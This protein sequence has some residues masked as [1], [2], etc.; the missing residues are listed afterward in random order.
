VSAPAPPAPARAEVSHLG[1]PQVLATRRGRALLG[2]GL[3][4]A[5]LLAVVVAGTVLQPAAALTDL[6]ARRQP[7]SLAHPFG[8]DW[9]GRDMLARTLVGLRTSLA[10]GALAA[11]VSAV[12]ALVLGAL[13]GALGRWV[14]SVVSWLVD[15]FLALPHL[16][17]LILIAFAAGRGLQG[18]IIAVAVTHWPSLTRVLRG[19]A[20]RVRSADYVA[21]AGKLGRGGW[22]IAR[23]HLLAH[24][25]P[26]FTV[27]LVL[28]FPHAILHEAA[29]S[30]LGLGLSPHSP[31]IGIILSD[32]MRYLSAGAW[33]LAVLP[34][35]AL[36]AVVKAVDL[37]G[38]QL[39]AL[40]DPRSAHQ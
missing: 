19:E 2:V 7:P 25:L 1:R 12:I 29:L 27:G 6:G 3:L 4:A 38:E 40:L 31:A 5:A 20:R 8:T 28:L 10:V 23:R 22:W 37:L 16:V 14:D 33:W 18:V 32:A 11:S 13:A 21:V 17:L 24:L 35:A 15:L 26:H 30:F 9:L 34:G 36:L 39:R